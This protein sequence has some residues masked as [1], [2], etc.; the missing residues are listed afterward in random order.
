MPFFTFKN[1]KISAIAA[2]VPKQKVSVDSF[3]DK[4]GEEHVQKF[5]NGTGV[6]EYRKTLE[7]QTAS[8]LAYAAA[9]Q[10]M[11]RKNINRDE[12]GVLVFC[13]LSPDY[14]RPSTAC[15]LHK[16]LRLKKDCAALDINMGCSAF[17]YGLTTCCSILSSSNTQKALLLVGE[18]SS[19]VTN[20]ND[21]STIMLMG[22]GGSALLLEKSNDEEQISC[23]LKTD[24]TGYQS[25]IA[26]AGGARNYMPSRDDILWPDGNMRNLY[27]VHMQGDNVFSFTIS[28]VPRAVKEFMQKTSTTIDYYDCFALH[29]ANR[30]ILDML[31]K[32]IKADK[33]KMPICLDRYG[34]TSSSS[35]PLAICDKYGCLNTTD[36][37]NFL[38]IGFGVG[39]SW[40]VCSAKLNVTDIYPIIETNEIFEEGIINRPEDFLPVQ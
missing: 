3:V 22:D 39:L 9:E 2:A 40:G 7:H 16:R 14:T 19:K 12:I 26:P 11:E 35:I 30:F 18:T 36:D 33:V 27:N 15:V 10:I 24:G 37:V 28:D 17:V 8:D 23:L 5:K 29:Q 1:I 34:N 38:M 25:I 32:K 6:R 21:S 13:S 31:C 4:F 20:P